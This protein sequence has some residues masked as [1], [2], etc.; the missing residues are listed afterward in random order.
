[1]NGLRL[2]LVA[3][4]GDVI[5][6]VMVILFIVVPLVGQFLKK[7]GNVQKEAAKRM[8]AQRP[9]APG[10]P[11]RAAAD[12]FTKFLQQVAGH[13]GAEQPQRAGRPQV[14]PPAPKPV[15]EFVQAEVVESEGRRPLGAALAEEVRQ[16][17]D[18][19]GIA[20]HASRLG[21]EVA[22]A[23]ERTEE[24]LHAK[25]DHRLG[26]LEG[27]LGESSRATG[28]QEAQSPEDR[29]TVPPA[30]A[31]GLAAMLTNTASLRQ[32]IVLNEI[33]QRPEHRW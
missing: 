18:T 14:R 31:A 19:D 21:G 15:E 11:A 8:Q 10:Q 7:L 1:M 3:G 6:I 12:E 24:R 30:A 17:I 16:H 4:I 32:A 25:F 5:G 2:L 33:L 27:T 29:I 22:S 26:D 13:R 28:V 23:D 20:R 9:N